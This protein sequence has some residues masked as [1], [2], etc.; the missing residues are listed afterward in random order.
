[1]TPPLAETEGGELCYL[2]ITWLPWFAASLALLATRSRCK[3]SKRTSNSSQRAPPNA[4]WQSTLVKAEGYGEREKLNDLMKEKLALALSTLSLSGALT[5]HL[6]V[7]H[8][9]TDYGYLDLEK[10]FHAVFL[11]FRFQVP[12]LLQVCGFR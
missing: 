3:E 10:V 6:V 12:H 5:P 8:V 11:S 4:V 7:E 1:M 2:T 9:H